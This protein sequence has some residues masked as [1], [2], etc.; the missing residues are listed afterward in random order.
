MSGPPPVPDSQLHPIV[1]ELRRLRWRNGWSQRDLAAMTGIPQNTIAHMETGKVAPTLTTLARI[2]AAYGK[3][4][5][6]VED[7]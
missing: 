2:A 4:P 3:R 7:L 5:G 1:A 6:L